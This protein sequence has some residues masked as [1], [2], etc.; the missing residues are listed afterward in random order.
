VA[1]VGH[2]P[3]LQP[4]QV[5]EYMSGCDLDTKHGTMSGS[6]HMAQVDGSTRSAVTGDPVDVFSET[7][8]DVFE[9]PV[10]E[11]PLEASK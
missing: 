1:A 3:I 9:M 6:F 4:G 8:P 7:N 5:F 11:F 2:L 10:K